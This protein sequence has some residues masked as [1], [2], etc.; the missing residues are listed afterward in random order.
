MRELSRSRSSV[1]ENATILSV[2]RNYSVKKDK[3]AVADSL[4]QLF[5]ETAPKVMTCG[6]VIG[7]FKGAIQCGE[8]VYALSVTRE[9][10]IDETT[11]PAWDALK[12][13]ENFTVTVNF[14]SILP[15]AVTE[16]ELETA[17]E[18]LQ[19]GGNQI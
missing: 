6:V 4:K 7:H 9:D 17:L 11:N 14:L 15:C 1:P 16:E 13:L 18:Q 8:A 2:R 3:N 12:V 10:V 5:A 19:T